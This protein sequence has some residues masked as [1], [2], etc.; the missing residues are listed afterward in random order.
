M[1]RDLENRPLN[2]T[3]GMRPEREAGNLGTFGSLNPF[4]LKRRFSE[5]M[6]R[7]FGDTYANFGLTG[8]MQTGRGGQQSGEWMPAI[9]LFE[10]GNNLIV[11]ADLPGINPDDVKVELEDDGL[12]IH[13]ETKFER[14]EENEG[15][16]HSERRYG[17]FYRFIP[18]PENIDVDQISAN[19][20]N[21]VL[22][23]SL[24][25]PAQQKNRKQIQVQTEAKGRTTEAKP[26]DVQV[27]KETEKKGA[28]A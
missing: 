21:G 22:E 24:P 23:I 19:Y 9:D 26:S 5:E 13:G 11:R 27:N 3:A 1:K 20:R 17:R 16:Y 15:V 2:R 18:L 4:S 10:R 8:P 12:V 28:K 25:K 7:I 14:E 6:D